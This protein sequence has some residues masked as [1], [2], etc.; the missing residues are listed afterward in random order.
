[1][2]ADVAFTPST[3]PGR[4]PRSASS[5]SAIASHLVASSRPPPPSPLAGPT[6]RKPLL[7]KLPRV[8]I[9]VT[10]PDVQKLGLDAFHRI[11]E[12]TCETVVKR[13]AS[14]VVVRVVRGKPPRDLFCLL[15]SWPQTSELAPASW[16]ETS[17]RPDVVAQLDVNVHRQVTL[18]VRVPASEAPKVS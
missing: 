16:R 12:D 13:P 8:V 7:E 4:R 14:V 11:G 9:E 15:P 3:P 10:P 2:A 18:G 6:G 5:N 17:T 1:M